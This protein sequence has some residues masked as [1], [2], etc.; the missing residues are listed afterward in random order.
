MK[1]KRIEFGCTNANRSR[2]EIMSEI[3]G[4][5]NSPAADPSIQSES[6]LA[7]NSI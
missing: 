4:K 5:A 7:S 3:K 2:K 6:G 1:H